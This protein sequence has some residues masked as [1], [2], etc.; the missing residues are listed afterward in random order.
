M[1]VR[2]LNNI[3]RVRPAGPAHPDPLS[4]ALSDLSPLPPAVQPHRQPTGACLPLPYET[5]LCPGPLAV[6]RGRLLHADASSS[7]FT[8]RLSCR[9]S[10]GPVKPARRYLHTSIHA[11]SVSGTPRLLHDAARPSAT[12]V[13]VRATPAGHP[14]RA[15]QVQPPPPTHTH[16][17]NFLKF[18]CCNVK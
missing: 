12:I 8:P 7:S 6:R 14:T 18:V 16:T 5:R 13:D 15:T 17:W 9:P 10:L 2:G 4:L 3:V 11:T 1:E